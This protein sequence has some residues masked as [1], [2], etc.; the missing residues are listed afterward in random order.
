[1]LLNCKNLTFSCSFLLHLPNDLPFNDLILLVNLRIVT[2]SSEEELTTANIHIST[3]YTGK[4]FCSKNRC[5]IFLH[6]EVRRKLKPEIFDPW[7]CLQ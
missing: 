4:W 5:I 1:M 6:T 7:I 2:N 3:S